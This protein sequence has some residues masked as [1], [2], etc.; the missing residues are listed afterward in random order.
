MLTENAHVKTDTTNQIINAFNV[1]SLDAMLAQQQT[2]AQNVQQQSTLNQNQLTKK[3]VVVKTIISLT[4]QE[5][6][7]LLATIECKDA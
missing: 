1:L 7:V 5:P 4:K 3:H 6:F 2:L